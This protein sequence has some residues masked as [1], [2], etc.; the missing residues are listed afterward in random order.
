MKK[1]KETGVMQRHSRTCPR[2]ADGRGYAPHR[3]IGTWSYVI[4]IGRDSNGKR[5]QETKGGFNSQRAAS[6]ARAARRLTLRT[7]PAD[8]H[9][10][11]VAKYLEDW[12]AGKRKLRQTTRESYRDY[13]D[14]LFVPQ[15]GSLRL[16]E[17]ESNPQ[18]VEAFFTWLADTPNRHG[19]KRSPATIRRVHA[20]LR[21]AL[22]LAVRRRLL[23][24]NPVLAVELAEVPRP[25]TVVWTADDAI[26]F[27][28]YVEGDEEAGRE[29][30]R[31][32]ALYHLA[33]VSAMRRGELLGQR[34]DTDLDTIEATTHVVEQHVMTR[35]GVVV[36]APK[37]KAGERPVPFD[38]DTAAVLSEHRQRQQ[39]ERVA[40]GNAWVD[41]GL[42]FTR[43]DGSALKPDTV[44]RR[45]QTL[46]KQAGV[47]VI[48]FHDLR[49]TS[50]SLG[51]EAGIPLK[52]ISERAG[53]SSSWFTAD[54]YVHVASA[55]ARDAG[56]R[57]G[58]VVSLAAVRAA[59]AATRATND[60]EHDVSA[61]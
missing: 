10:L 33:L 43:E 50:I 44:S 28:I 57:I 30:E 56:E 55:Q 1:R 12:L 59:R 21:G 25:Q 15:L 39:A 36:G 20:A 60:A 51:L 27:L 23:T 32:R 54:S 24:Y 5:I 45:F 40:A 29:P 13:L 42:V 53:H 4:E 47:P 46:C 7:R 17:L 48:R 34:W 9:R 41:T 14:R 8:A 18:H 52:V 3:C 35:T 16:A 49:H 58:A 31:L 38:A 19:H 37:T 26:K 6:D 22:N 2:S 11:T 61:M